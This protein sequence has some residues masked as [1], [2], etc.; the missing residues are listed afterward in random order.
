LRIYSF[1]DSP[2]KKESFLALLIAYYKRT[3]ISSLANL[4]IKVSYPNNVDANTTN[5]IS[6]GIVAPALNFTIL[7]IHAA[8]PI[9]NNIRSGLHINLTIGLK[10][11]KV[12][13]IA[14]RFVKSSF[15]AI[16][17]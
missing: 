17:S 12:F 3:S 2:N 8:T 4:N 10:N 5:I 13:I 7:N 6:I 15:I 16:T 14:K 11:S 1:I 9:P